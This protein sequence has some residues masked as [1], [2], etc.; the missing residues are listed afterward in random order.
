MGTD[1]QKTAV[2]WIVNEIQTKYDKSFVEFYG[3]EIEQAKEMEKEQ[4]VE[5][6]LDGQSIDEKQRYGVS[7][8]KQYYNETFKK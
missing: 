7:D 8:A 1:K 4:I 2:E 3:A 5:A 6:H